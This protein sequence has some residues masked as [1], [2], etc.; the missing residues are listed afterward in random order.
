MGSCLLWLVKGVWFPEVSL[1][2]TQYFY[3][4]YWI[5]Y[6]IILTWLH[7]SDVL[8]NCVL[9][10]FRLRPPVTTETIGAK[11]RLHLSYTEWRIM[12]WV[13]DSWRYFVLNLSNQGQ[14]GEPGDI[15]DVSTIPGQNMTLSLYIENMTKYFMLL[16]V[17]TNFF[18]VLD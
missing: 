5:I 10:S 12:W 9:L 6:I 13:S 4:F 16:Y 18:Y 2:F 11:V 7:L 1:Q 17:T 14:K 3:L 8:N 15:A